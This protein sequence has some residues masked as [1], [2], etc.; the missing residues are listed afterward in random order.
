[1]AAVVL[2]YTGFRYP[3][4]II[5]HCVW[6]YHRF[7]LSF[8]EVE[9]RMMERGVVVSYE[10]LRQVVSQNRANLRERVAPSSG[11]PG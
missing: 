9:E 5:S 2:S 11:A 6:L 7:P 4:E 3:M 8:R 1:M 10:T